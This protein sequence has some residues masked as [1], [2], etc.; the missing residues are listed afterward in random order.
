MFSCLCYKKSQMR[1]KMFCFI[2]G[3]ER[4]KNLY[5]ITFIESKLQSLGFKDLG[6][7]QSLAT[8]AVPLYYR[9]ICTQG[10]QVCIAPFLIY[11]NML[12]GI[13]EL[14]LSLCG[15]TKF[16]TYRSSVV[17]SPKSLKFPDF[18][19]KASSVHPK[20]Q[21]TKTPTKGQ[22][23]QQEFHHEDFHMLE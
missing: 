12:N 1:K 9:V 6:S 14:L 18:Y 13:I 21:N 3:T 2:S 19:L 23:K 11:E 10:S 16:W 8:E 20:Q 22:D 15:K 4:Q 7:I 17:F 5:V